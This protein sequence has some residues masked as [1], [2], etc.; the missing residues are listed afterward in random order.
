MEDKKITRQQMKA[1]HLWFTMLADTL[2]DAGL[3]QRKTLKPSVEIPWDGK[4]IKDRLFRPIMIAQIGVES[5]TQLETKDIDRLLNTITRHL[6]EQFGVTQEFP[7]IETIM[8]NQLVNGGGDG[9]N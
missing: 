7:S 6:G 1:L 2:N 8:M 5:T 9:K 3:D 4:A